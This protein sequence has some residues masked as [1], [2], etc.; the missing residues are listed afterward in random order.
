MPMEVRHVRADEWHQLRTL[1]LRAL[2]DAP[3][4][5]GAT[6]AQERAFPG[7]V[8]RDR[9]AG[10][11]A[12]DDRVTFVAEQDGRWVGLATCLLA[13]SEISVPTLVGMFVDGS[14]GRQGIGVALVESVIG[15]ARS[16]GAA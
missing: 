11:A 14:V 7:K 3:M 13:G 1:R 16:R 12:G 6:F 8:W 10:G 5:F 2:A 9:A 4:A 15:W